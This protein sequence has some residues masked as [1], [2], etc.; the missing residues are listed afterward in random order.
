MTR[1]ILSLLSLTAAAF[2]LV[3]TGSGR[4]EEHALSAVT[5]KEALEKLKEGNARFVEGKHLAR[6]SWSWIRESA[7]SSVCA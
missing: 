2:L 6:S 1:R 4:A 5:P 3:G 7:T